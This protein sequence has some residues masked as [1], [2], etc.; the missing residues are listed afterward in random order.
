MPKQGR[1]ALQE[2]R[3]QQIHRTRQE[4][5]QRTLYLALGGVA[6]L[7]VLVLGVG[8]YR[9]NYGKL[10]KTIASVN[11]VNFTVR[12]YQVRLKFDSS[13]LLSQYQSIL[14]NLQTVQSDP[15]LA[16]LKPSLQQ[17]QQQLTQQIVTVPRTTLENMI[18]DE[19]IRQE[20]KKRNISV[21]PDEIDQQF[22]TGLGYQR[23]T[24][25][26]TAGPSPTPTTTLTP[27]P[28]ST[29]ARTSTPSLSP[30][31]PVTPTT[32][33][34]T[35]TTGPTETPEPTSTPMTYQGYVDAKTKYLESLQKNMNMNE[36]DFRKIVEADLLRRKLQDEMAK[37]VPTG[38]EQIKARHILVKTFEEA[39]AVENRLKSGE[40]FGKIAQEVSLDPG[41][42][43]TGGELDWVARGQLVSEFEQTAFALPLNQISQPVT[44]TYGVHVIQVTAH[45]QNRPFDPAVL[46][47]KQSQAFTD[48][49][50][51][52][53]FV[54]K[55]ERL[56]PEQFVPPE[57]VRILQQF[58]AN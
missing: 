12:D 30:T 48:W 1:R 23:A 42:K 19:I 17:Q 29:V 34:V 2:T 21:S 11:G 3:K 52:Q 57:I 58:S 51:N 38:G 20:A 53:Q 15:S 55:V 47:Q 7:V 44:S 54:S 37:E 32:P 36:A 45:E 49:L 22:E 5:Q 50:Q 14:N 26:P 6:L 40:D 13:N 4:R 25:T 10:D 56:A 18:N 31:R 28:T 39:V 27:A 16:F 43:E 41:S 33:T 46:R 35:P 9:E 24:P 8:Y